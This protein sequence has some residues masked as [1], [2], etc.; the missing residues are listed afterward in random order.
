MKTSAILGNI[1]QAGYGLSQ[2][3]FTGIIGLG[4]SVGLGYAFGQG[5]QGG[6]AGNSTAMGSSGSVEGACNSSCAWEDGRFK[7]PVDFFASRPENGDGYITLGEANYHFRNGNGVALSADIRKLDLSGLDPGIFS[8]P[9]DIERFVTAKPFDFSTLGS[10]RLRLNSD[11]TVSALYDVYDFNIDWANRS[12]VR[13]VETI[14]GSIVAGRGTPFRIN[15]S[16]RA[17]IVDNRI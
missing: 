2:G 16:G 11:S 3:D 13:N 7:D 12:F 8:G 4:V 1:G 5:A 6:T 15:F 9:G 17:Y 10:I 14:G